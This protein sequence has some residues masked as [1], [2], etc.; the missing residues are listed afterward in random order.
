MTRRAKLLAVALLG[1]A[2]CQRSDST[3]SPITTVDSAGVRITTINTS[4]SVLDEWTLA[5]AA[6]LTLTAA[7]TGD[8]SA[9]ADIGS[10]RWLSDG[11]IVVVD[12]E[13]RRLLLFDA[14]GKL[15][16]ALGR[17]GAGPG[18]FRNVTSVTVLPGDS[19]L[20]FDRSLRRLTVWHPDSGYVRSMPVGGT[21]L[22]SWPEDAWLW[23][24]GSI[25]VLQLSI[26]PQAAIP[27]GAG[28]RRWPMRA[29]LT[30]LD[31]S[32]RALG[33]SPEF[34]GMYTGLYER[35]DTRLPFSNQPFAAIARDR[36]IYFGSGASFALAYLNSDFAPAGELRWPAHRE[37]LS[38]AEVAAVKAEAV[39]L[40]G[41]RVPPDQLA[42]PFEINFAAQILPK[43][44]PAIGR[45]FVDHED[46]L[47]VERF[48]A[49]RLG[50][51]IQKAG[52]RWTV[53]SRDGRPVA[54]LKIPDATR[55]E[56][57]HGTRALLV[58]RDSLDVQTVAVREIVK[59]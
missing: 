28:V 52:D 36:I 21:S 7:E 2:S 22:E 11:R 41:T 17:R 35:G 4:P 13:A 14:T 38:Q 25:V 43:E 3:D 59:N 42:R 15:V 23:P 50:S 30:L 40:A 46:R 20:T 56:D 58:V 53:L 55:L 5:A 33:S 18:E 16:R 12:A 39:A 6:D 8:S 32:G 26:T 9:F 37:D 47:W 27:P 49:T 54:R 10:A 48:E 44:R 45:V 29:R 19:L 24:G 1:L 51:R 31:T 34:D 57:V